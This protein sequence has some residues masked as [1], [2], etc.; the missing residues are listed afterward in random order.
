MLFYQKLRTDNYS[1]IKKD[2]RIFKDPAAFIAR[3]EN[4]SLEDKLSEMTY[5]IAILSEKNNQV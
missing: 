5:L 3:I 4:L 2:S 1:I